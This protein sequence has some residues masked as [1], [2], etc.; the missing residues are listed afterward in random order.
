MAIM[1]LINKRSMKH[2]LPDERRSCWRVCFS[3]PSVPWRFLP[4]AAVAEGWDLVL[5]RRLRRRFWI[6]QR[7]RRK[8]RD[9][10]RQKYRGCYFGLISWPSWSSG[11][12]CV[13]VCFLTT[14]MRILYSLHEDVVRR[15]LG[16]IW[17]YW[18]RIVV[19]MKPPP[20]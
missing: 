8:T 10:F 11:L 14:A 20:T 4:R 1:G 12:V 16:A 6:E 15:V 5:C 18:T 17:R 13:S 3:T 2:T 9:L 7:E 19:A